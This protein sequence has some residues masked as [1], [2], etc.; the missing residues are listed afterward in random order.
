LLERPYRE[1]TKEAFL[2]QSFFNTGF[3]GLGPYKV[4]R[5]ETG[6][7]IDLAAFDQ[8]IMGRPKIDQVRVQ[9]IP[10]M[11]TMI[12]NLNAK[13]IQ[14]MLTLG[15]AS[16]E[17]D[18]LMLVKRDWEASGYGTVLMDPISY[19]FMEPQKL[20]NPTPQDL[21][22]PRVRQALLL[23]VNRPELAHAVFAEY[24]VVA[25]SWVHP[26][27]ATYATLK[28]AMTPHPYDP[29]RASALL[30]EAG[31]T[32]G[33]DGVLQKGGQRFSMT[34]RD[35]DGENDPLILAASFKE[36]GILATYERRTAAM[37]RDRQDRATF[38]GIDVTSNPMGFAAVTRRTA[39][40][41][42]PTEEN[43]WTGTNRGGYV[44]PAWDDIDKRGLVALDD[45]ARLDIEREALRLY[46]TDLPLMP[47]YFRSDLIPTGNVTGVVANTGVSHRGFILHTWNM[48]QWDV[49][50]KS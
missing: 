9:F 38:T 41:N 40:Y 49:A 17:F 20:H 34:M 30:A 3:V 33:A 31:W 46:T 1:G 19:R 39:S 26:S 50:G 13:A 8:F 29:R 24:G 45:R 43:R 22:D 18:S 4:T 14:M 7:H 25:D 44:N 21:L 2:G 12:A 6:S 42:T 27:F 47:L 10:D 28:D 37:V 23:A 36:V 5:W 11:N 15:S 48:H 32:P 16:Q 35:L